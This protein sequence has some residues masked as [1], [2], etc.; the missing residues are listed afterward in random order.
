MTQQTCDWA[1]EFG[2]RGI[3]IDLIY[4]LPYQNKE[5]FHKTIQDV[6]SLDPD[7][8]AVFNYAH[9]PWMMKTQR[10][11]DETRVITPFPTS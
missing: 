10:K 9:V 2:F 6:L 4:G 1:R 8:L 3:N 11:F 7:R 5:T